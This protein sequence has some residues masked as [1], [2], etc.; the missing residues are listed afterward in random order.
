MTSREARLMA[1]AARHGFADQASAHGISFE[2]VLRCEDLPQ[3]D[4]AQLVR[5]TTLEYL[6]SAVSLR[7]GDAVS[8]NGVAWRVRESPRLIDEGSFAIA[9]L[10][11][12]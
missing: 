2:T 8:V 7:R 1:A 6:A 5:L 9:E 10:E 4:D 12:V 11:A 3:M